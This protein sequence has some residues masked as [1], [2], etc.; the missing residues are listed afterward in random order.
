[1]QR[2]RLEPSQNRDLWEVEIDLHFLLVALV[3]L[4]RAVA[5]AAGEVAALQPTLTDELESCRRALPGLRR[6]RDIGEHADEYNISKGR[7]TDVRRAEV[8][9]WGMHTN[10]AGG[11]VWQWIGQELDL[12]YAIKNHPGCK[13][14][15]LTVLA[16]RVLG[17]KY[18]VVKVRYFTAPIISTPRDLTGPQRQQAYLSALRVDPRIEVH[19]GNFRPRRKSGILLRPASV[20]GQ[21][22]EI[23][24]FEEKG[25]DV[26]LAVWAMA[27]AYEGHAPCAVIVSGDSDF[28]EPARL[29]RQRGTT[30]GVIIP[31]IGQRVNTIPRDFT[32]ALRKA[33]LVAS[34]PPQPRD[35]RKRPGN[36]P[37]AKLGIKRNARTRRGVCTVQPKP[38]GGLLN[39]TPPRP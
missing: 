32:K 34:Q 8:Q 14:L 23:S 16:D 31:E 38:Y 24:T 3:R 33:D 22:G 29:L 30:V 39:L 10:S 12:Y 11:L 15:S 18:K 13:W 7:R 37:A 20:A 28:V 26:N 5:R 9:S 21:I 4:E 1:M 6:M 25:S 17:P 2:A 36:S 27:D 19:L 35:R